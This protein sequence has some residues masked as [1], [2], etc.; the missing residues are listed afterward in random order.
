MKEMLDNP[1]IVL[2][3]TAGL[4]LIVYI[5]LCTL[6]FWIMQNLGILPPPEEWDPWSQKYM[7]WMAWPR[8][9]RPKP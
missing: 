4:T 1:W 2:L 3:I 8:H 6:L 7:W 5:P 9:R